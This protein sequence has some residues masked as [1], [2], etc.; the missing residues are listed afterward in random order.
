M[1]MRAV[2]FKHC[3]VSRYKE[4]LS[5]RE[6]NDCF[7]DSEAQTI[8]HLQKAKEVQCTTSST[9]STE[10]QVSLPLPSVNICTITCSQPGIA[11]AICYGYGAW[12]IRLQALKPAVSLQLEAT[13]SAKGQSIHPWR[14]IVCITQYQNMGGQ[15]VSGPAHSV[16]AGI[17]L[18]HPRLHVLRRNWGRRQRQL[19]SSPQ[20]S[21]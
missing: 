21:C 5:Q 15:A 3:L 8:D 1:P 19:R 6:G 2:A 18:G 13:N 16:R 12:H 14:S 7:V 9:C 11:V 4:L 20:N 17:H 10:V